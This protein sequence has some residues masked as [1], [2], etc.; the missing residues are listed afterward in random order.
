[1]SSDEM[2]NAVMD[3][4]GRV[5]SGEIKYSESWISELD[6]NYPIASKYTRHNM[7]NTK[8]YSV[9]KGGQKCRSSFKK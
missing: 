9:F 3:E 4:A 5:A 6:G 1:M 7:T 2:F 8:L